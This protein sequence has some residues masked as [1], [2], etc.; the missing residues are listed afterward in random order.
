MRQIER[1]SDNLRPHTN[2]K[3]FTFH[4]NKDNIYDDDDGLGTTH[5]M[6]DSGQ[7]TQ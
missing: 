7:H 1:T 2:N 3:A 6:M 5:M 4:I